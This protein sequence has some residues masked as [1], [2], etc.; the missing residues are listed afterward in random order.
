MYYWGGGVCND[1][2]LLYTLR[3]CCEKWQLY[4]EC[5]ISNLVFGL[6]KNKMRTIPKI[7]LVFLTLL[8]VSFFVNDVFSQCAMCKAN[9][10]TNLKNGG[11]IAKGLNAG[12]LYLMAIP[13]LL[14]AFIFREQLK[15]LYFKMK[16]RIAAK[17]ESKL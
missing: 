16:A 11:S 5:V 8:V 1:F 2:A 9:A 6:T 4:F 14:L 12:I 3:C 13:Y 15:T 7:A 17:N 10:E